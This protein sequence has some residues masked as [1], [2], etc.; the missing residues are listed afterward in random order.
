MTDFW[1][2]LRF[3]VRTA[4]RNPL[5]TAVAALSLALG[6]GA[7]TTIFSL[8]NAIFLNP[9]PVGDASTVMAV[10][11]TDENN[12]GGAFG[13]NLP[14]SFPNF[15]DFRDGNSVFSG[16][17][18][19]GFAPMN[20]SDGVGDPE[21]LAAQAVS[22]N[23]FEVMGLTPAQGRFF[24]PQEDQVPGRDPV[25]VLSHAFWTRRFAQDPSVVGR[26]VNLNRLDYTVIGVAPPGF[27]GTFV[28]ATTDV[29]V[30]MMMYSNAFNDLMR[31]MY[32][33][34]RAL[35]M[36]VYGRLKPGVT[37]QQA[38]ANIQAIA[39]ALQEEHPVPNKGRSAIVRPL[40]ESV[41]PA[42]F[43]S[44]LNQASW[45]LST[46][47]AVLLLIACANV[48]NLLLAR[49]T[50]RRGEIAI[51][52]SMGASQGRLVRQ[53]LT[54]SVSLA[55]VGG[56]AGL[57]ISYWARDLL[58]AFRPPFME[59][60]S[61]QLALDARVL[62]FTLAL[63]LL[64]GILFGLLPA[65]Q[66]SRPD[67]LPAL[68]NESSS[69]ARGR[70]VWEV[71]HVL[72][73][74]QVALSVLALVGAGL[75]LRSVS[76]ARSVDPGF[77]SQ[78]LA[79]FNIDVSTQGYNRQHGLELY[80]LAAERLSSLPGADS[81]AVASGPP[82]TAGFMRSVFL[83]GRES[84][85]DGNGR[86]VEVNSVSD[87]YFQA[88]SM[89][90][91]RGRSFQSSDDEHTPKVAV[92]NQTMAERFWPG[93][94]AL[95][96]R[97]TFFGDDSPVEVVGVVADAKYTGLGEDPQPYIYQSLRQNY[98]AAATIHLRTRRQPGGVLTLAQR[99]MR[100]IEPDL[101]LTNVK[102]MSEIIDESLWAPRLA[103]G[104]LSVFGL[105]ALCL[106]AVGIYGVMGY[107]VNQRRREIGLRMA[108][109]ADR[110]SVLRLIVTQGM[111][112]ALIGVALGIA[113]ALLLAPQVTSL[114]WISAHDPMTYAVT[115]A[116]LALVSLLANLFPAR[117]ATSVSPMLVLRGS[118]QRG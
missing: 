75:F 99:E 109:G 4:V 97:F 5:F 112:L 12:Q 73:I 81:V 47:V 60:A 55:L 37:R 66:A 88:V 116:L 41:M 61:I 27:N 104:M 106:A 72:V 58:W 71:R 2:D 76:Q 38:E 25:A 70:S 29:W 77:E 87:N 34:R 52:L 14:V 28:L 30:P 15:E 83:P 26:T 11:T 118:A 8:V 115:V 48:A 108:L 18:A 9:L 32:D 46:V 36:F 7:S 31:R 62:G 89:E 78:R 90:L 49:A 69:S 24:L 23:Y 85:E 100:E 82:L 79:I 19:M 111:I 51:R 22:G 94:P 105:A 54:E 35:T 44:M 74:S 17:S 63:S 21:L 93:E 91:L 42:A 102:S 107:A 86:L 101:A 84:A 67:L 113:A 20:F 114:L 45:V 43:R 110:G 95:G 103:A 68:K 56:V 3:A 92:V 98:S 6:I 40:A 53:M 59:N 96:Q 16:M 39:H 10:F 65:L 13:G 64:T 33:R 57:A 80:R 117:R 50:T 1:S